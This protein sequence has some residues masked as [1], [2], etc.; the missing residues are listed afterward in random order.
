M[1]PITYCRHARKRMKD[2]IVTEEEVSFVVNQ[3]DYIELDV[4]DRKN[5]YKYINDRFI[6]VTFKEEN[7]NILI[8]TVTI[9]K[10]PFERLNL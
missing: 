4:K 7:D 1:K 3:A 9:R 8:I 10:K 2:R 6:R 5:A